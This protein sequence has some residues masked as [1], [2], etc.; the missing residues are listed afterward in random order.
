M[1][2]HGHFGK[3]IA[4]ICQFVVME[5]VET[6]YLPITT[7]TSGSP[8]MRVIASERSVKPPEHPAMRIARLVSLEGDI[9]SLTGN[10]V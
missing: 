4:W 9:L 7:S 3:P 10:S 6:V 8:A 1:D 2:G 5:G